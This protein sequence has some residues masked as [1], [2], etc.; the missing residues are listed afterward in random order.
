MGMYIA[1]TVMGGSTKNCTIPGNGSVSGGNGISLNLNTD[2]TDYESD[3]N[4]GVIDVEGTV[5]GGN[6]GNGLR[7]NAG[8]GGDGIYEKGR[9]SGVAAFAK[10]YIV[11]GT[12]KGGNG[13]NL[14]T[15]FYSLDSTSRGNGGTGVSMTYIRADDEIN[16]KAI[17]NIAG[18]GTIS[19]GDSG[20]YLIT[21]NSHVDGPKGG[22]AIDTQGS[23]YTDD[24]VK[25]SG[26]VVNNKPEGKRAEIIMNS[27][28]SKDVTASIGI[29]DTELSCALNVPGYTGKAFYTWTVTTFD[30]SGGSNNSWAI[31]SS[32]TDYSHFSIL[33]NTDYSNLL[34]SNIDAATVERIVNDLDMNNAHAEI[35]CSVVLEDGRYVESGTI[36]LPARWNG[37]GSS[38]PDPSGEPSEEDRAAASAVQ[39]MINTLNPEVGGEI[40]LADESWVN[41]IRAE[42]EA[43]TD[44]QKNLVDLY[45][46]VYAENVIDDLNTTEAD[47]VVDLIENLPAEE[48]FADLTDEAEISAVK[49]QIEEAI[50]AYNDLTDTQKNLV[51]ESGAASYLNVIK[52]AFNSHHP[53]YAID[54][55]VLPPEPVDP[56]PEPEPQPQPGPNVNPPAPA[57]AGPAEIQDLPAV[58]IAK[59]KA[60]K[61]KVT[62]KWKKVSKKNLKK[63]QG[64][65]IHVVGPG[66]DKTVTVGK[67][68][69]S[70][71]VGGL[72]SKQKYTVQVRAY[73]WIGGVKHVSAWKSKSVKIK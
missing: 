59:P 64:I 19:G 18:S 58:K 49:N 43:L 13:G 20:S 9:G 15:P 38:G 40:T 3:Q 31:E 34:K 56:Q 62:V 25:L 51:D 50:N 24:I 46:L 42:Y 39:G 12:I 8:V 26:Q 21:G 53:E 35:N 14:W 10:Y 69:T 28:Y 32:G 71:K 4:L 29:N 7:G 55:D 36:T 30:S 22:I 72:Q 68:K 2:Y 27:D 11:N 66:V 54:G 17:R 6:G 44:I 65:E 41:Q 48:V 73:A 67:K 52:D 1:G 57:A 33:R 45:W 5:C 47:R 16:E 60:A 70:K 63:I 23:I 37:S 61:K